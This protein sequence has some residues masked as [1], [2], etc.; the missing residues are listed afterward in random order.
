[1]IKIHD[2][3]VAWVLNDSHDR[4]KEHRLLLNSIV[5]ARPKLLQKFL[6]IE[7]RLAMASLMA[8][9]KWSFLRIM[10]WY[11]TVVRKCNTFSISPWLLIIDNMLLK[12][13]YVQID[14]NQFWNGEFWVNKYTNPCKIN[15]S[16]SSPERINY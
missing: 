3:R 9:G 16:F 14:R 8:K 5:G 15:T 4:L 1:M 11:A 12:F 10:T 2:S 7:R 13:K 6:N